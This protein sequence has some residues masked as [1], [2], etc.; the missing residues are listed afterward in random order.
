VIILELIFDTL[1]LE[2]LRLFV[3]VIKAVSNTETPN[4]ET[5]ISGVDNMFVN[6]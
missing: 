5:L 1:Q 2:V 6:I 4:D 3:I